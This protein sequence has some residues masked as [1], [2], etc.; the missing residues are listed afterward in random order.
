M[1]I[2]V[3]IRE[4]IVDEVLSDGP[5]EVEIVDINKDY[6]DYDALN[7]YADELYDDKGMKSC[8]FTVATFSDDDE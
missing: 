8:S 5:V 6:E 1:K 3:I 4:G 2:K 7:K